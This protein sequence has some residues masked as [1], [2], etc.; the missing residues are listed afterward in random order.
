MRVVGSSKEYHVCVRS[1]NRICDEIAMSYHQDVR[2]FSDAGL[3][4]MRDES[5][6][7]V[8]RKRHQEV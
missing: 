4:D 3:R 8:V 6:R 7:L 1:T 2:T 5:H